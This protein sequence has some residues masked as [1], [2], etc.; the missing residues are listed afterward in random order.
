MKKKKVEKK[1]PKPKVGKRSSTSSK[2]EETSPRVER[3]EKTV[4]PFDYV[5]SI[6]RTKVQMIRGTE[7]DALA[8]KGYNP[9]LTNR[10]LS[11][12]VDTVLYANEV[13]T[14]GGMDP[15]MQYQ[16]LLS[17]VRAMSRPRSWTK[18]STDE[19]VEAI[20]RW[21]RVNPTRARE[22][23]SIIGEAGVAEIN[24]KMVTGGRM[25]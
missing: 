18:R 9:F 16:Y 24:R 22:I 15:A 3:T 2:K 17:S 11:F 25:R 5:E 12:H 19:A 7:N 8:E 10:A 23:H 20:G 6:L 13:N 4:G 21:Y 14:R 1:E